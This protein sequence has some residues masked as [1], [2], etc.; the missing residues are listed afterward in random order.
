MVF[1]TLTLYLSYKED[2]FSRHPQ[3]KAGLRTQFRIARRAKSNG[4]FTRLFRTLTWSNTIELVIR[5]VLSNKGARTAGIDG[6]T[7]KL[8]SDYGQKVLLRKEIVSKLREGTY[9]PFPVKRILIPK[10]YKPG[11][12]RP[13]GIPTLKDRVVQEALRFLMEPIFEQ[14]LYRH[15]Y[16][17]RPFRSTHH[18]AKRVKTL[19]SQGYHWIIEGDIKGFF[20]NVDHKILLSLLRNRISDPKI[21]SLIKAILKAGYVE[22]G[23]FKRSSLGTPQ[24][25]ILSP[26]LANIYLNPLSQ[27]IAAKYENLTPHFRKKQPFGCFIVTYADDWVILVKGSQEQ[28]ETLKQD[29][30]EFLRNELKLELS[31]EKTHISH[32]DKGIDFLGF[33]IRRYKKG[34]RNPVLI[35][36]CKKT[37]LKFLKQAREITT[38]RIPECKHDLQWIV[39]MNNLISGWGEHFRRVSSKRIFAKLDHILHRM[40]A[41]G[42]KR[43][44]NYGRRKRIRLPTVY[45]LYWIAYR[46]CCNRK[47]YR[48]YH[49][50][51]F[52]I[53]VDDSKQNAVMIE[54]LGF[55]PI[56]Y[57]RLH[58]QLNPYVPGERCLL[59]QQR[60]IDKLTYNM[61]KLEELVELKPQHHKH[62]VEYLRIAAITQNGTCSV[63]GRELNRKNIAV[64]SKLDSSSRRSTLKIC[65]RSCSKKLNKVMESSRKA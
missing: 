64:N 43:K 34:N 10:E 28:A 30:A 15:S 41:N 26:L 12:L 20:D 60:K 56:R 1:E 19:M 65:C 38:S 48:R 33:N 29:V 13:L 18:A 5:N 37:Q 54:N 50:S 55:Y 27:L 63:C 53:F 17:F 52:G 31:W 58:S 42:I 24:G 8:Y 49:S 14:D 62:M 2:G 44:L 40:L 61:H 57:A 22:N 4:S 59:E 39:E 25:G 51:N 35:M 3:V 6:A 21:L 46:H 23:Q 11:E 32:G 36:P 16:G 45:K 7:R 9:K 47:D